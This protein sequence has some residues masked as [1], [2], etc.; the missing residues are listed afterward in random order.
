MIY[1]ASYNMTIEQRAD[2][3][4][5]FRLRDK[6]G[7]VLDLTSYTF[8]AAIWT[9]NHIKVLDF[10]FTWLNQTGGEFTLSLTDTQTSILKGSYTWDLLSVNPAGIKDYLLRGTVIIEPGFTV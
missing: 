6:Q 4:R 5:S 3:D 10:T 7:L 1:P 8:S 9:T 2:F